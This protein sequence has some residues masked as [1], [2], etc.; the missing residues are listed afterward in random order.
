MLIFFGIFI[1]QGIRIQNR[2]K[3]KHFLVCYIGCYDM[4]SQQIGQIQA[5]HRK[6]LIVIS[7]LPFTEEKRNFCHTNLQ[8][9]IVKAGF[10]KF[11]YL[12]ANWTPYPKPIKGALT[13]L[14]SPLKLFITSSIC[15]LVA[16]ATN[17]HFD[18]LMQHQTFRFMVFLQIYPQLF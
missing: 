14:K 16:M 3:M 10:Y 5:Y 18:I 17:F 12:I 11:L 7:M 2:W 9:I 6:K 1:I 15:P 8:T 13:I 4:P